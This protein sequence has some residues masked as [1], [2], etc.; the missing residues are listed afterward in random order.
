MGF[1]TISILTASI[2]LLATSAQ[3]QK[4]D[5][6]TERGCMNLRS[7][8]RAENIKGGMDRRVADKIWTAAVKRCKV[9]K[10]ARYMPPGRNGAPHGTWGG[11]TR[12]QI[13]EGIDLPRLPRCSQRPCLPGSTTLFALSV[14]RDREGGDRPKIIKI[15]ANAEGVRD[16]FVPQPNPVPRRTQGS[17]TRFQQA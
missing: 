10:V 2:V 17:G 16:T 12:F 1:K 7:W 14:P 6:S 15:S 4:I 11:G 8:Q 9:K 5:T 3:A 13:A